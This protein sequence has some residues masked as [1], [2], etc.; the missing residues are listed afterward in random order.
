MQILMSDLKK[1]KIGFFGTP[2]FSLNILKRLKNSD[3]EIKYVVTQPPSSSGRGQRDNLS[4]VHKWSKLNSYRVFCPKKVGDKKFISIIKNIEVDIIIVVAYGQI[5]NNEILEYPKVMSINV[6][7][8]L[9]PRWRG[10][11]PIQRAIQ[12]GDFFSGISIMKMV[13]KLDAGPVLAKK[14]INILDSDNSKTLHDKLAVLGG[15][16]LLEVLVRIKK[17][18]YTL[19]NQTENKVTYAR[20]IQKKEA[21]IDW[22]MNADEINRLIRAFNPY[23]GAWTN[24]IQE[25]EYRIKILE[26]EVIDNFDEISENE[27]T[28]YCTSSLVVKCGYKFLKILK[29]QK[30]GKRVMTNVEFVNGYKIYDSILD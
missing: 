18:K 16:L 20:K 8:S 25:K 23:P 13:Q 30:E 2:N 6:H 24:M 1:I 29:I 12:H 19:I 11:A 26:S 27:A 10:A 15:E 7:A 22:G 28:G 9:L 3:I 4:V 5:I 14:K 17:G 21:K